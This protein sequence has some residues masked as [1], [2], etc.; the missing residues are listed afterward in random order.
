[1]F[2]PVHEREQTGFAIYG[3]IQ[4][5][6]DSQ[7]ALVEIGEKIEDQ[8]LK[9]FFLAESLK[10]A[11]FRSELESLLNQEGVGRLRESHTRP[12]T[13]QRTLA[14]LRLKPRDVDEDKLLATAEQGEDA[15]R[16]AYRYAIHAFLPHP[17]RELLA[18]QASHIQETHDFVR[19][20]RQRAA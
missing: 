15:A 9:R 17:V 19:A 6:I 16:E 20:A 13:V 14:G 3:V 2:S 5:L 1:M 18:A 10:R 4:S 7:E 12:G 8:D 11:E